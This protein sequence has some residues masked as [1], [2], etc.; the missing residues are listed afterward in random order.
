MKYF[1]TDGFRGEVSSKLNAAH[2]FAIGQYLGY[3]Y[4]K[5]KKARM[6]IGKDTRLSGDVLEHA[7]ASGAAS[8]GV[9]VHLL[10]VTPTPVVSYLVR[11]DEYDFG[12]MISASHNPY[13]DNGIKIFNSKG[14]K[15]EEEV[16]L[17]IEQYL[18]SSRD[19]L[20]FVS[21]EQIGRI[22]NVHEEGLNKY[23]TWLKE[24]CPYSFEGMNIL[25][26]LANGSAT[27]IAAKVLRDY[28]ANVDVLSN[29]P[30][31]V[32]INNK[33]GS[34]HLE[35]LSE[36]I[37]TGNYDLGLAFDGDADR[38][39]A[40]DSEGHIIDGDIIMYLCARYLHERNELHGNKL[41]VTVMSNIGLHKALK[42]A[43]IESDIVAV[44]DK[45]VSESLFANNY[46][47]GGEQ[48]GHIIFKDLAVTGD[49]LLT[50]INLV[51]VVKESGRSISS[52]RNDIAIYPQVLKNIRV[53]DK[54]TT[55]N[56]SD[57]CKAI[58]EVTKELSGNGRV[59]VR[60]SGTEELIRVMVEAETD[61]LCHKYVDQ[62]I[63]VIEEKGL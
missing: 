39:L 4:S 57:V 52:L 49:G 16:E 63:G 9:D 59:L 34:T 62:V 58:D 26:D 36:T 56:D 42:E 25:V 18:D 53:K 27:A 30:N 35:L 50:A 7:L 3:Y 32:N 6:I 13:V 44:G 14:F 23:A 40:V 55:L 1:G 8:M 46:S 5:N 47:L 20:T 24:V 28:G 12:V 21:G 51:N 2:A 48:S 17:E 33:C 15:L 11:H 45:Y 37:K 60:P 41:V 10:G 29:E 38:L 19:S 43:G 61:E 54:R 22:I 31:G